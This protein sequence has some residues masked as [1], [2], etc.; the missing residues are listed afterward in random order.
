MLL[1][2]YLGLITMGKI[3]HF[4]GNSFEKEPVNAGLCKHKV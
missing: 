3:S 1:E 4:A 2:F